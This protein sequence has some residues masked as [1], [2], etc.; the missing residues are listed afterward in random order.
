M[1]IAGE[2]GIGKTTLAEQLLNQ[3]ERSDNTVVIG[4]GRCSERLAG[5]EA[6]L[7]FLESLDSLL[8][9]YPE[10]TSRAIK[11]HAPMWYL[12]VGSTTQ[13]EMTLRLQQ[14]THATLLR[15]ALSGN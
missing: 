9:H 3:L 5:T 7:P 11:Q 10:L 13:Q 15:S 14:P 1:C 8:Q 4:R 12:Q 6:Y 2:A